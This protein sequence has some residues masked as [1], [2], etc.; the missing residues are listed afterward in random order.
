MDGQA[1]AIRDLN[2]LLDRVRGRWRRTTL[3]R[4]IVRAGLAVA[5]ILGGALLL[6]LLLG[7]TAG[8]IASLSA[9]SALSILL[10]ATF[11]VLGLATI[12]LAIGATVWA[13]WPMRAVPS[14]ARVARYIEERE[15][16]LD[17]RLV[18]AVEVL[19]GDRGGQ[20]PAFAAPMVADAGRR[21]ASIDPSNI[22]RVETLRR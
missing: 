14:N 19:S 1:Q 18:S 7:L 6:S 16:D 20:R 13:F 11:A 21:A 17:D 22:V 12:I 3:F 10:P 4:A 8:R 5:A 9:L 2:E 15:P